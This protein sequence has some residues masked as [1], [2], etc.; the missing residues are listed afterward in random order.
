MDKELKMMDD[1][2][3]AIRNAIGYDNYADELVDFVGDMY[4]KY[5]RGE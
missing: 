5:S 4:D 2:Y 3:Y 1:I